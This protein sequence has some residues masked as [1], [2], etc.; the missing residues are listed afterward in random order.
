MNDWS[1]LFGSLSKFFCFNL[2]SFF[3]TFLQEE[4]LGSEENK[5]VMNDL[6]LNFGFEENISDK[7]FVWLLN[8]I[9]QG[10]TNSW[11]S[12]I[13]KYEENS[14]HDII[15]INENSYNWISLFNALFRILSNRLE[16]FD[17]LRPN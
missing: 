13:S 7:T 11:P 5:A 3:A 14:I 4:T 16:Y 6:I 15:D 10:N 1:N 8:S 9:E 2:I 17:S 12:S